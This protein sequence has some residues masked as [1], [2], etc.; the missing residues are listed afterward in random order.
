MHA[1]GD[2][3]AL[4]IIE[5]AGDNFVEHDNKAGFERGYHELANIK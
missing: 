3:N 5:N 1:C 2:K 4:N